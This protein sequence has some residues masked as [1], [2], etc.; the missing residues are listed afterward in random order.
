MQVTEETFLGIDDIL[1]S[2]IG[3]RNFRPLN[4]FFDYWLLPK[5][6]VAWNEWLLYSVINKYSEKYNATVSSNTLAEAVPITILF[7]YL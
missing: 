1:K 6:K 3:D 7:N 2:F 5:I 4:E